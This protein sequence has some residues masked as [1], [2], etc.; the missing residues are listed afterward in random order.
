MAGHRKYHE[1]VTGQDLADAVAAVQK[2][3]SARLLLKTRLSEAKEGHFLVLVEY[4]DVWKN[5]SE[6]PDFTYQDLIAPRGALDLTGQ[7]HRAVWASWAAYHATPW[8][9]T[10][11]MVRK[12]VRPQ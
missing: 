7:L 8:S 1:N 2:E 3:S 12:S 10:P 6:A 9:W 11:A 4:R 5:D